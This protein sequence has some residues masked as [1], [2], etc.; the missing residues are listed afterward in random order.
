MYI[1][2]RGFNK[3]M[4]SLWQ[5]INLKQLKYEEILLVN[6]GDNF[7]LFKCT[8]NNKD[9]KRWWYIQGTM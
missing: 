6:A 2:K 5:I 3:N 1:T 9:G 8:N 4:L 7:C